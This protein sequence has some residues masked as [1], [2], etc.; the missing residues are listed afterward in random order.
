MNAV[1]VLERDVA[2]PKKTGRP[3]TSERDDVVV[4]IDKRLAAKARY[5]SATR[6]ISLAEYLSELVRALVDRDFERATKDNEK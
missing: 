4:K 1:P 2:R 3:A 6:N 5:V